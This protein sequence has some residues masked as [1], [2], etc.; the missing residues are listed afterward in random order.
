MING[1]GCGCGPLCDTL[2]THVRRTDEEPREN[3][4]RVGSLR[5]ENSNMKQECHPLNRH[6]FSAK[7]GGTALKK[8]CSEVHFDACR[9]GETRICIRGGQLAI[10]LRKRR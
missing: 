9:C 1:E 5:A 8:N 2:P 7:V 4:G 3:S 6:K 10:S